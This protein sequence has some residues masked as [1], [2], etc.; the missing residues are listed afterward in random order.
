VEE[1]AAEQKLIRNSEVRVIHDVHGHASLFNLAPT[2]AEQV[3]AALSELLD[4]A[5]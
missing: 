5:V 4:S 2:Y 1:C 3:D